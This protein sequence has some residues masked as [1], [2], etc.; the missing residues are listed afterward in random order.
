VASAASRIPVT[1]YRKCVAKSAAVY[2]LAVDCMLRRAEKVVYSTPEAM[3]IILAGIILV[4][5]Y[6]LVRKESFN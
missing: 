3:R 5:K 6:K 2:S 4:N 1:L